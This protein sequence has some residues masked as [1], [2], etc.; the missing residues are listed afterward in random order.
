MGRFLECSDCL[1]AFN[2]PLGN[3]TTQSRRSS[4]LSHADPPSLFLADELKI[5]DS[6]RSGAERRHLVVLRFEGQVSKMASCRDARISSSLRKRSRTT[7]SERSDTCFTSS[8]C[9]GAPNES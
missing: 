5:E 9:I 4:E 7:P 2:F 6:A 3:T 1:L 8:I